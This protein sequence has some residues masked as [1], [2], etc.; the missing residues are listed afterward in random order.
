MKY[1]VLDQVL[2]VVNRCACNGGGD[3][4]M[5]GQIIGYIPDQHG[6]WYQVSTSSG[7]Y[8]SREEKILSKVA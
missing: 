2:F 7:V 8:Y 3:S 1:K 5:H 4:E 6:G